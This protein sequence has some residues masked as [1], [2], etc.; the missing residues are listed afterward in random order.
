M[1]TRKNVNVINLFFKFYTLL[2]VANNC[3]SITTIPALISPVPAFP[4]SCSYTRHC[5]IPFFVVIVFIKRLINI[6]FIQYFTYL[7]LK[8]YL[9]QD[10]TFFN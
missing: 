6:P 8:Q 10:I 9:I 3:S 2:S 7:N 5:R 1:E 4:D